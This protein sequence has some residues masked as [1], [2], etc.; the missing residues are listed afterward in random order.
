[1]VHFRIWQFVWA[2]GHSLG[3]GCSDRI[4]IFSDGDDLSRE[5][6]W[7]LPDRIDGHPEGMVNG[8]FKLGMYV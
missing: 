7:D 2:Q 3:W 4:L 1:M 8:Y 6:S 5:R